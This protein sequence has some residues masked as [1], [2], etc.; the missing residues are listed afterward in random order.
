M[1]FGARWCLD[2]LEARLFAFEGVFTINDTPV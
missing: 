1:E 2:P